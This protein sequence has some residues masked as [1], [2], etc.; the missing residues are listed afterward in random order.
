MRCLTDFAR[1]G[2]GVGR[3]RDYSELSRSTSQGAR[4][5]AAATAQSLRLRPRL[6]L[7]AAAGRLPARALLASRSIALE[8]ARP[9]SARSIFDQ[10]LI[11]RSIAENILGHYTNTVF[12]YENEMAST[13]APTWCCWNQ[14]FGSHCRTCPA[15]GP[16]RADLGEVGRYPAEYSPSAK[17]AR[18]PAAFYERDGDRLR[19]TELTRGPWNPAHS[20]RAHRRR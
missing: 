18:V 7:L 5:P 4:H 13:G 9:G 16:A 15:T 20:T 1:Q 11:L 3:L 2:D 6:H 10:S 19:A 8:P 12:G 14:R 17:D